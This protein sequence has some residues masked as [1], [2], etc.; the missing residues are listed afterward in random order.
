MKKKTVMSK[1]ARL[2]CVLFML[3]M[4]GSMV[5]MVASA[6]QYSYGTTGMLANGEFTPAYRKYTDSSI[7]VHNASSHGLDVQIYGSTTQGGNYYN[8][9]ASTDTYIS[10]WQT[11]DMTNWVYES[12][13]D[14]ARLCLFE[15][16]GE[17][18]SV[19]VYWNLDI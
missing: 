5:G 10:P 17:T 2:F 18:V 13:Y 14:Y 7:Q 12:E 15:Y 9:D 6:Y 3:V 4:L 8:C 19:Q 1:P 11:R 16:S